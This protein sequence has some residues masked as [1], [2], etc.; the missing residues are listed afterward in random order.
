MRFLSTLV[1][2]PELS[3]K[4]YSAYLVPIAQ[5]TRTSR[6]CQT[7]AILPV[8]RQEPPLACQAV[9][10]RAGRAFAQ[11]G[12]CVFEMA[13][14]LPADMHRVMVTGRRGNHSDSAFLRLAQLRSVAVQ[15]RHGTS[16]VL[17]RVLPNDVTPEECPKHR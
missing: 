17:K 10:S 15:P 1:L 5:L 14:S 6:P 2:C 3:P 8:A 4:Q 7:E 16:T 9:P 13:A 11:A 12:A